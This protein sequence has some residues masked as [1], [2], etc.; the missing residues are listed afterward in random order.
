MKSSIVSIAL[1]AGILVSCDSG[2]NQN[3]STTNTTLYYG[4]DI[5]TMEGDTPMYVEA[6]IQTD[7]IISFVGLLKEAEHQLLEGATRVNLEG[8]TLLPAFLDGHGHFYNVGFTALCANLLPPPDGEGRDVESIVRT[9][10]LYMNSEDGKFTFKKIGW[11]IG[12]GY[13]DSQLA[14]KSHPTKEDLDKISTELPVVIIHQSGHLGC[15]NTKGLELAGI[16][17]ETENPQGGV[18]RKNANGEPTGVLEENALFGVLFSVMGKMDEEYAARC[19]AKGQAVYAQY[20]YLTAQDGR[21]SIEQLAALEAASKANAF[22]LDVVAYPDITLGT[23]YITSDGFSP[24]HTYTNNFRIGGVK[25][26][27]DGS[28]QG[29]TAWLGK[30]YHVN[31]DGREGCYEGYPVMSDEEATN[32]VKKAFRNHWQILCHSNGDA[33][34]QQYINA[35]DAAMEE[36][37]Y[38]NHRTVLIHGQTLRKDQIPDLVRLNIFPSLFP[39]HT[40]YW[41]DWHAESVLGEERAEYISPCKDV[42]EAGLQI[43]SHHDAPVTE[44]NSMRVLDATVNRVTRSGRVL[45]PDQRLTPYQGLKT[46]TDWAAVQYFEEDS[47]GTLS[48]GKN[49][50]FVIL[51]ENPLKMDP[52]E[53]HN[54]QIL[55]SIKRG[56]RVYVKAN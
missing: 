51:N 14:S 31:P 46:L 32:Y 20:G 25:L 29:K 56:V 15:M 8:K 3:Q 40:Y 53:I 23:D 1:L 43:T 21:T 34:I 38:P 54:I 16:T 4:G 2:E 22:Y 9:M 30:C 17:S 35:V 27:L 41:G 47:K 19:I 26:T 45:G 10:Q 6:I 18:I 5:I 11:V 50:D 37:G 7:G 48:V 33:A 55:E 28:P 13:D 49:A 44:P 39:M 24:S 52:L 42:I 36:Y 12:N